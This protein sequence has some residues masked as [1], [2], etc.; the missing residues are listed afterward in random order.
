MW[1]EKKSRALVGY[2]G[3]GFRLKS[4]LLRWRY[5]TVI[6]MLLFSPLFLFLSRGMLSR[7]GEASSFRFFEMKISGSGFLD[8]P[9]AL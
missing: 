6:H 8:D 3:L 4:S 1:G 9:F 7:G 2:F 5:H